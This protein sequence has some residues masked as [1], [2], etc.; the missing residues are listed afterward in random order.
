MRP[1][2]LP[3]VAS[4]PIG[5]PLG[6]Y[7]DPV[8]RRRRVVA[9]IVPL[10]W[11]P[12]VL[13]I[14][15]R[16]RC[17][18]FGWGGQD[19]FWRECFSDLPAQY[20]LGNLSS[21]LMGY[22][23]GRAHLEQPVVAGSIMSLLGGLV[24]S[25]VGAVDQSR[26]YVLMWVVVITVLLAATVWCTAHLVPG[27]VQAA[28]QVAL[29]PIIVTGALLSSDILAVALVAGAML[30]WARGRHTL[31]GVLLGVGMMTRGYVALVAVALLLTAGRS[32]TMAAARRVAVTAS[33]TAVGIAALFAVV[34]RPALTAVYTGWWKAKAGYGSPWLLSQ[35]I[36]CDVPAC[37]T[38]QTESG[39]MRWIFHLGGVEL[40]VWTVTTLALLGIGLAV[41]LGRIFVRESLRAPTWPQVALVVVALAMMTGKAVPVQ[42]SLWLLPLAA[43]AGVR[44]RDHLIWAGTEIAYFIAVWLYIGALTRPDR[45][46]PGPWYALFLLIRLGGISW[47]VSRV[48]QAAR[49]PGRSLDPGGGPEV[50]PTSSAVAEPAA[51]SAPA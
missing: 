7:A 44:W 32:G 29:S 46:L 26:S 11:I 22:L 39:F 37:T 35:T 31:T 21:G 48:W 45:A 17:V 20:S 36:A 6:T 10:V 12:M 19:Q 30:A 18:R 15:Q 33:G 23:D 9:R 51:A 5:G 25:N 2:V 41:V 49:T 24:P 28:T 13:A 4:E 47:I 3:A 1:D 14:V 40:P 42:A 43:A 38:Q 50:D 16:E 8:G 27:D 34:H